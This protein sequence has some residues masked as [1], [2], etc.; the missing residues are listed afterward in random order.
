MLINRHCG[1]VARDVGGHCCGSC[2]LGA[3]SVRGPRGRGGSSDSRC[4]AHREEGCDKRAQSTFDGRYVYCHVH[5]REKGIPSKK[6]LC[7]EAACDREVQASADGQ[8]VYCRTHMRL[9][10]MVPR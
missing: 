9:H 2:V 7:R 1:A 5:M 8:Y 10:G 3:W 6:N 4:R